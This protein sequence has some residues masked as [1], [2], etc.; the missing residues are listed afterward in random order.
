[1]TAR[2]VLGD[3]AFEGAGGLAGLWL[4]GGVYCHIRGRRLKTAPD[5][6]ATLDEVLALAAAGRMEDALPIVDRTIAE[7]PRFWQAYQCR[8]EL[9]LLMGDASAALADFDAALRLAPDEPHLREWRSRAGEQ[10]GEQ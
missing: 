4:A 10:L 7:N 3:W 9:R 1:M 6:A 8:G 5:P 2:I